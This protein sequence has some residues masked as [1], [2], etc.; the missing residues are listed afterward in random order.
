MLSSRNLSGPRFDT[1]NHQLAHSFISV[2]IN[3]ISGSTLT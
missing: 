1:E 2:Q 3:G